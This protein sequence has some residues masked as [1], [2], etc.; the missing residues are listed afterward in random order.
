LTATATNDVRTFLKTKL[1]M[2]PC[3]EVIVSPHKE[4]IK[5][6]VVPGGHPGQDIERNFKWLLERLQEEKSAM[7]KTL[8][9]FRQTKNIIALYEWLVKELGQR[10]K[11]MQERSVEMYHLKTSDTVKKDITSH[12]MKDSNLR[13]VLCST[14][15]SMGINLRD[16]KLVVHYGPASDTDSYIQETGR[17][18][19]QDHTR[20][21]AV[22]IRHKYA[23]NSKNI[24]EDM[25]KFVKS[26]SCRRQLLMS[27]YV[28]EEVL[29]VKPAHR[30]CDCCSCECDTCDEDSCPVTISLGSDEEDDSSSS[31]SSSDSDSD[32]EV[33]KRKPVLVLSDSD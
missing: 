33:F 7:D 20:C 27:P 1:N 24:S 25:K 10:G 16:V 5:Y 19:R 13:V 23:L 28:D 3:S 29:S 14:S 31:N 22:I 11:P 18:G 12:F 21:H 2:N 32:I 4:N 9:F 30:C 8:I 15:F 6:M 26:K 17:A